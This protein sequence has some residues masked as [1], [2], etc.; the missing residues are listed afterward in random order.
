MGMCDQEGLQTL[1]M[2]DMWSGQGLAFSLNC[3]ASLRFHLGVLV[4]REWLSNC[5]TLGEGHLP[6]ASFLCIWHFLV[7]FANFSHYNFQVLLL[8]ISLKAIN[9]LIFISLFVF[10]YLWNSHVSYND[11][12]ARSIG[13]CS[14]NIQQS[15]IFVSAF[16]CHCSWLTGI[17]LAWI[18]GKVVN[19]NGM[20]S[21]LF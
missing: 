9:V 2:R 12:L 17:G 5:F 21:I 8:E 13:F 16:P 10:N 19:N 1:G 14:Q 6:P 11:F 15:V 20:S 7:V 3:S 18:A 4:N